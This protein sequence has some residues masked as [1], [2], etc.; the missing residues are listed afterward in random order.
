MKENKISKSAQDFNG[1][2]ESKI[3]DTNFDDLEVGRR[4][5]VKKTSLVG[6]A[7]LLGAPIVFGKW[8]PQSLIPIALTNN[9]TEYTIPGK[10]KQLIILNT[11]PVNAEVPPHLLNDSVTPNEL[12]FVR[13]NGIPP[14]NPDPLKWVLE[15][16]GESILK[17]IRFSLEEL[18]SK[19]KHYS[20]NLTLECGGNGRSEFNPPAA[21]NQWSLGAVGCAKWTGIRVKD[22]LNTAGIKDD[23]VYVAYYG[24]DTHLSGDSEKTVISR[25]VPL[26]KA[27]EDESLIAWAVNDQDI[28]IMNGFPLRLVFGGW[29]ASCSGKWLN[30]IV[31]RNRVHDG[32]KMQGKSYRVPCETVAPGAKVEDSKMCIIENMPVKSLI[33][34]PKTGGVLTKSKKLSVNG[35]A[36][37]GDT[38]V[39]A[40]NVSIDFGQ[41]WMETNLKTASN[42]NAWQEWKVEIDF[43]ENGYY[44]IWAKATDV[45]GMAQPMVVPGWNPKGYLNN[46]CHRIAIK[47]NLA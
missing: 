13:N 30:K 29:P 32:P 15:I 33:T 9:D 11:K 44:E 19:F 5:F 21:G 31:V 40:V 6:L 38:F 39:E 24:A 4:M 28:P 47:V 14:A 27:M 36:W 7:T 12:L 43:P 17:P 35:K 37:A 34:Y 18:K 41:T 46:A 20:Y 3:S 25:G 23:A 45:N 22:V 2:L 1:Q 10:S 16:G 8:L 42:K 26:N